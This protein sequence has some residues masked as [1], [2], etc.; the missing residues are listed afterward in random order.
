MLE[1]LKL[2]GEIPRHNRDSREKSQTGQKTPSMRKNFHE[3]CR[4]L[5]RARVRGK[6]LCKLQEAQEASPLLEGSRF[7]GLCWARIRSSSSTLGLVSLN[8]EKL[9]GPQ[10]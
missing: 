6:S 8:K 2:R 10:V 7:K 5:R 1:K 3:K 4:S 9:I